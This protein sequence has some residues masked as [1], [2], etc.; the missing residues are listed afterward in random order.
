MKIA[1]IGQQDFGKGVL[2]PFSQLVDELLTL[3]AE[4]ATELGMTSEVACAREIVARGTSAE[5][6]RAV[7]QHALGTPGGDD[8][9][10]LQA[11]VDDLLRETR[12]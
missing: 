1:I 4:D 10:A 2:V 6:Q 7:F 3:I 12:T 9:T 11:V 8:A 5:R